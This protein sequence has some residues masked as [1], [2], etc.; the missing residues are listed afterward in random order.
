MDKEY[1]LF[2]LSTA[3]GFYELSIQIC[4]LVYAKPVQEYANYFLSLKNVN[5]EN[6]Q[7][8]SNSGTIAFD[9]KQLPYQFYISTYLDEIGI[10]YHWISILLKPQDIE[11]IFGAEYEVWALEPVVPKQLDTFLEDLAYHWYLLHPFKL[12]MIGFEIRTSYSINTLHKKLEDRCYAKCYTGIAH[13]PYI[14]QDNRQWVTLWMHGNSR[15]LQGQ[16]NIAGNTAWCFSKNAQQNLEEFNHEIARYNQVVLGENDS[17]NAHE[18]VIPQINIG[19]VFQHWTQQNER[20]YEYMALT[21]SNEQGFSLLDLIFQIQ[22]QLAG[23][24]LGD[25]LFFEGLQPLPD[26]N[27]EGSLPCYILRCGS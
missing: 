19:I 4:P 26:I 21:A 18:I 13:Y 12:G 5:A 20:K 6:I 17:W 10:K 16:G 3:H 14:H 8:N 23:I 9:G 7:K 1:Y 27:G 22:L 2:D 24:D 11:T 15:S 25:H